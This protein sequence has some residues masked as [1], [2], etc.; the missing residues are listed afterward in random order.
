[1]TKR[2]KIHIGC[3]GWSYKDWRDRFYPRELKQAEWFA[4]YAKYFDTVEINNTFYH[5]PS[6]Q[7]FKTWHAQAPDNFVYAVK[8]NRYLTHIKRLG[9][10]KAPLRKFLT[11]ARQLKEHLGPILYQLPPHWHL[12]LERLESFLDLLPAN[13]LHVFE[14]R[15]QSWITEEVLQMLDK[16]NVSFCTHDFSGL[17]VPRR[18]VGPVVYVRFHGTEGPYRGSYSRRVLLNWCG[19]MEEQISNGKELFVYFN[20]DVEAQAIRDALWLKQEMGTTHVR[21]KLN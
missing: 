10:V 20:N 19:W 16:R 18:A 7:V 6:A 3:S 5:L 8:A 17:S 12:N 4:H 15:D 9:G 13:L 21:R 2:V 11:R 14:F 1:M